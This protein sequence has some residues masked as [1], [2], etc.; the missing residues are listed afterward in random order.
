MSKIKSNLI[1]NYDNFNQ[2]SIH[3]R[4]VKLITPM[5]CIVIGNIAKY[6]IML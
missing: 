5:F 6:V 3:R 2:G 1:L 4:H